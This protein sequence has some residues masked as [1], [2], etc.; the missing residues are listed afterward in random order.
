MNTT[1][2]ILGEAT[3]PPTSL[4]LTDPQCAY[5]YAHDVIEGRF[6]EG[7][8]TLATSPHWAYHYARDIIDGPW[9]EAEPVFAKDPQFS[10]R[11]AKNVIEGR[12]PEGEATIA[13]DTKYS[14]KYLEAFPD[15]KIE[16]YARE[17]I[18]WTQ[19]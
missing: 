16:W 19:L 17:W 18:D 8:A 13:K 5:F 14:K 9:P 12:F 11:Y 1:S 15:A 4:E 7:E 3:R 6:P 10:F 2:L